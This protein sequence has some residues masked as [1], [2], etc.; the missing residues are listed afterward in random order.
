M[1]VGLRYSFSA[2]RNRFTSVIAMVS[3]LGMVL[4][5]ASLITVLSIMNGFGGELRSR[6]LSL[7]PHGYIEHGTTVIDD[8]Q[9]LKRTV[10][11][12][13]GI[14]AAAPYI[15]EKAIFGAG[16][17]LR[18]GVL[19]AIDPTQEGQISRLPQS[20]QQ[21]RLESLSAAPFNVVMG[22]S[23]AR[24]LGVVPGDSVEVTVPRLT[25]T[26][27]GVFPRSKRLTLTGTFEIGAQADAYQAYISLA[28][29]QRLLS[30]KGQVDGLQ[31]KTSELFAAPEI[32]R[33]VSAQLPS[34]L[35][36][37]D[38][39]Q[40]Q[41]SLF[42]AVKMEKLMVSVL[43]LS[44]VAVAAF[45]I[46]STLVMSV[47]EKRGDIAVLRTMG[48]QATDIMAIFIAHG[49][50]L[51]AAGISIGVLF[52][53]TLA[54][55]VSELT[56]LV[57]KLLGVKIFDPSVYF[58]SELPSDLQWG[59]VLSVSLASLLLSLLATVYPAWRAAHIAPAEVLRYE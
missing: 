52:G 29:G 17:T 20:M 13:P 3:M 18:G 41:G 30:K 35:Q 59:D 55:Y 4:G 5:V 54:S 9:Q 51:A 58:I 49:M 2:K 56:Q 48:A 15:T 23:L 47:A 45:N 14:L 37:K 40:T 31:V 16:T 57:E 43:L 28:G 11:G 1:F 38:W 10:E 53:V 44:V 46:V 33:Q 6:I 8:W 34:G 32:L 22:A 25:V 12:Y 26:P 39:S 50:G 21:G 19:T 36:V 27:L 42:R 7:V 24:I